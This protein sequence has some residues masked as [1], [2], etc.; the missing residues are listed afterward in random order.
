MYCLLKSLAQATSWHT[1]ADSMSAF[2]GRGGVLNFTVSGVLVHRIPQKSY[3]SPLKAEGIA[4]ME[5]L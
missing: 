1:I 3:T 2:L 5:H 4:Q